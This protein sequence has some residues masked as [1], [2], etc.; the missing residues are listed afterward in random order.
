MNFCAAIFILKMEENMQH[1]WSIMLYDF[2]KYKNAAE[3]Q[4]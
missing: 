1:F 3:K 2:T 4:K